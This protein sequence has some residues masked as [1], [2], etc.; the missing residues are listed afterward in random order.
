MHVLVRTKLRKRLLAYAFTHQDEHYYVRELALLIHEDPGN[1]SREL[2]GLQAEGLYTSVTRGRNKVYSLNK[3][4]PLFAEMKSI[5]FKTIG[6]EGSLRELVNKYEG[7]ET[8]FIYGSFAKNKEQASS[9]IDIVVVGEFDRDTFTAEVRALE[10]G[11]GREINFNCYQRNE[12]DRDRK[13]AG[14]FLNLVLKERK[15]VLKGKL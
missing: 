2:R 11:L 12:F 9:D 7:I 10:A 1:L 6:V 15:V 13:I 14:G 8:A 3:S 4:Y 5:V